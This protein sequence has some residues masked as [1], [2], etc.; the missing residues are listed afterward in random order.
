MPKASAK[1]HRCSLENTLLLHLQYGLLLALAHFVM[2]E[3]ADISV[4]AKIR[5]ADPL[6]N[7]HGPAEVQKWF[8]REEIQV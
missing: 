8:M 2:L 5:P 4:P 6:Q 1:P 3:G 7:A